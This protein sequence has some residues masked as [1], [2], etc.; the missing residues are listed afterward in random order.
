MPWLLDGNNVA[1]GNDREKVRRAALELAHR[2]K[3]RLLVFFDGA[4]PPG[5]PEQEKLGA[6][7]IRYVPNADSA[8]LAF[9]AQ[10]PAGVKLVTGDRALAAKAKGLGAEVVAPSSFWRKAQKAAPAG[11][12]QGREGG[13]SSTADFR[14]GAVPLPEAP[15][16]IARKRKKAR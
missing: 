16:R 6:V 3:L 9:L 4:P 14:S 12:A 8:I 2:E 15:A 13:A 10:R 7:E 5:V 1:G 11:E